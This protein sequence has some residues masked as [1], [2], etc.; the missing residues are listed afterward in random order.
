MWLRKLFAF[1][2]RDFLFWKSYRLLFV[3]NI[4]G[5]FFP[6]FIFYFISKL[7]DG[8]SIFSKYGGKYFPFV[9][10]GLVVKEYLNTALSSLSYKI[11][12]EQL[13]GTL[14]IILSTPT[15]SSLFIIG[16]VIWDFLFGGLKIIIYIMIGMLF[17]NLQFNF[18]GFLPA[19]VVIILGTLSLSCLGIIS[20][21]FILYFKRGDPIGW[22]STF[23]L[24]FLSGVYFP[25]EVLPPVLQKIS[26]FIPLTYILD[27]LR[28]C[29]IKGYSLS[30]IKHE[31]IILVAFS[32][33][34]LPISLVIFNFSLRNTLK[35]GAYIY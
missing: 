35:E 32:V 27:S 34:F 29:L 13:L 15:S 12:R 5:M 21:S 10:I 6:M 26:Q 7:I 22:I 24:S 25:T 31:M 30:L 28:L 3:L 16:S 17:F 8:S 18:S 4:I 14:E 23:L 11:R 33:I 2:K 19:L 1:V 9:F 20:G